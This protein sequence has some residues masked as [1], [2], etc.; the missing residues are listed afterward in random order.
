M[1]IAIWHNL[2]SGGGKRALVS[3]VRGL[4]AT[5]HRLRV[6]SPPQASKEGDFLPL[7]TMVEATE[8]HLEAFDWPVSRRARRLNEWSDRRR[9]L[10]A[11]RLHLGRVANEINEWGPDVVLAHP[12]KYFRVPELAHLLRAP[13]VLYLQEPQRAF[14]EGPQIPW[15]RSVPR[16][17]VPASRAVLAMLGDRDLARAE[18]AAA[19]AFDQLLVNSYYSRESVL[20]A[21]GLSA[22]V[23]YLGIDMQAFVPPASR[24]SQGQVL[25]VG[26]FIDTK[27]YELALRS[28]AELPAPRPGLLWIANFADPAAL[29][30]ARALA[31]ALEVELDVRVNT[32]D[33]ELVEAYQNCDVFLY[34]P[35]LEPFGLAPL[36]AS[37]CGTWVVALREAGMRET[38]DDGVNGRLVDED[39]L[40]VADA[41]YEGMTRGRTPQAQAQC[42]EYAVSMWSEEAAHQRL[43]EE[44]TRLQARSSK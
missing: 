12:C 20:R 36:E 19:A 1:R 38:V 39:A 7:S 41:V 23:C 22:R 43:L 5:G 32:S 35:R 33:R 27:G 31:N 26:S 21:Y 3:Q 14:F 9:A 18:R 29:E 28:I 6:W 25:S 2:P 8:L 37:A 13:N 15:L 24:P 44:L 17:G 16:G 10:A 11:M 34:L 4:L 30:R 42:R 40:E